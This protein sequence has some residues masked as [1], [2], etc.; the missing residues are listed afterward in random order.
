M[1]NQ[2]SIT[3]P[4]Y[5]TTDL[6]VP[7]ALCQLPLLNLDVLLF[8]PSHHLARS[9][10][11]IAIA[12]SLPAL[13]M[14]VLLHAVHSLSAISKCHHLYPFTYTGWRER[15]KRLTRANG[16]HLNADGRKRDE[17]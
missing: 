15:K 5:S 11:L 3:L 16:E 4:S 6:R 14:Q 9:A 10:R 7:A 17:C 2:L 13:S 1:Y 12:S 8:V